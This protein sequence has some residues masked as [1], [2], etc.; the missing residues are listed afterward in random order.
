MS[1][2]ESF[3]FHTGRGSA[4]FYDTHDHLDKRIL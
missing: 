2:N 1:H 3:D 4:G